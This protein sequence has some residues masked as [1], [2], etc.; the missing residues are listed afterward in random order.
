MPDDS[1]FQEKFLSRLAEKSFISRERLDKLV[2]L[3]G[4]RYIQA[5]TLYTHH[6]GFKHFGSDL[7]KSY[8]NNPARAEVRAGV[9]FQAMRDVLAD[10]SLP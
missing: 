1:D 9:S 10:D 8:R 5:N 4:F 6:N 3:Y 2:A 7:L